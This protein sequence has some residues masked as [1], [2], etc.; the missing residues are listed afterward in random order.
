LIA[1]VAL[2]VTGR[3]A[4][5]GAPPK[6]SRGALI[7]FEGPIGPMLEHYLYRKLDQAEKYGADLVILEIDSP[8]GFVDSSL[9]VAARLDDLDWAH[10]VAW[11]PREALSGAA[12][13]ALG[14]GEIVMAPDAAMGD[15][16]P[17]FMDEDFLFRHAPEKIRTHLARVMRDLAEARDRP[18]ALAE[19]MVNMDLV[20]YKVENRRSGEVTYMSD[21]EIESH[22]NRDD[23][24]K[25][26]PVHESREG[27]FLE[28]NGTRAVEL[29]L[30]DA[31]LASRADLEKRYQLPDGLVLLEPTAVDTAVYVL[32]WPLVTGLLL[33]V[34]LVAL[35]FELNIPGI[36]L[37]GLIAFL[38]F[39][40]F[41][42]SRFLGGTAGWL[43]VVLFV[44]GAVFLAMEL[45]VIPG[46]GIAGITGIL[47][48]LTSLVLAGQHFIVPTTSGEAVVF[49]RTLMVV[50][51]SATVFILVAALLSVYMGTIPVLNR[52]A[53][54]PPEP[55]GSKPGVAT[56]PAAVHASGVRV[57]DRG[58][59]AS[60][61]RPAGKARFGD[62]YV[63]VVT[64]GSFVEKGAEVRVVRVRGNRVVVREVEKI[65]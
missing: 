47:L 58:T 23:W 53:L 31:N 12:F 10:S 35:Y 3:G 21:E 20:V 52:L 24:E 39:A 34:G 29:G 46:F 56:G 64:E 26:G 62:E 19:A 41:F 49:G 63:D 28:V 61:L 16:G 40:L 14:C 50:G 6:A 59:A 57:E 1:A 4:E 18:P 22:E 51:V 27:H 43:E 7:R 9:N 8:G 65:E 48:L 60:P 15:A 36:G 32:N 44:S 33:I 25:L 13:V 2:C 30:A 11:V 5:Q 17:I 38:C 55:T 45:F 37:G 42:W 54:K